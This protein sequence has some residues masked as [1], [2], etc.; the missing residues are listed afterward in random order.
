MRKRLLSW[1]IAW[2]ACQFSTVTKKG[3]AREMKLHR[4]LVRRKPQGA[5]GCWE[6][7]R[8][9]KGRL[10]A[11]RFGKVQTMKERGWPETTPELPGTAAGLPGSHR[12]FL[13]SLPDTAKS[14]YCLNS[15]HCDATQMR[16]PLPAC[17]CPTQHHGAA[18]ILLWWTLRIRDG[19]LSQ[20]HTTLQLTLT[21][22]TSQPR[23]STTWPQHQQF[24]PP[25]SAFC[26]LFL[27]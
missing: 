19:P 24:L 12:S 1:K 25:S 23:H 27:A 5:S 22:S 17:W 6:P 21:S 8:G 15:H 14:L 2:S 13:V 7:E 20:M 18:G 4:A 10:S 16:F 11:G 9:K 3:V 26:I